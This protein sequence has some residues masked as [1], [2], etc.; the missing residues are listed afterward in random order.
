MLNGKPIQ[1]RP[2]AELRDRLEKEKRAQNRSLNNLVIV[3]LTKF[4]TTK[5]LEQRT[6]IK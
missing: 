6:T 5:D 1:I 3:I 4:F 2:S